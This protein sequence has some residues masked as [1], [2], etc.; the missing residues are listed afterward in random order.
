MPYDA[1]CFDHIRSL[2][3]AAVELLVSVN[4]AKDRAA[5]WVTAAAVTAA[6]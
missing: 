3:E 2:L 6:A 5:S 1:G 4:S